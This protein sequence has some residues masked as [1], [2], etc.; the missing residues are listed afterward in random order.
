MSKDEMDH[1]DEARARCLV[2]FGY[3][4]EY[5]RHCLAANK[6][7]YCLAAYYLLGED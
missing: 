4:E 2:E 7:E 1:I 5:V 3:P 6:A